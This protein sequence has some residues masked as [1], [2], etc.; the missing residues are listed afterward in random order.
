MSLKK[1]IL[2]NYT[3]Q[4]YATAV[5]IIMVPLYITYMGAEAYGLVGFFTMLQAWFNLLDM[6]FTP[7]MA[8][9]TAR[10]NG[11][12]LDILDYRRLARALEGV[13]L[14]TALLG[15]LLLFV[16]ADW[17]TQHWLNANKLPVTEITSALRLMAIIVAL[18]WMGGMYRGV[19]TGTER[20]VW[21]S[22]FNSIIA[23]LRFI[24]VLPVLM[25][26]SA[27]PSIFFQF[28]L[29]VAIFELIGLAWMAYRLLPDIPPGQHI[30]W[31]WAPL[32][33]VLKFS[34]SIAFTSSVGILITQTDKLILSKMLSL[35]DY[36]YFTVAV[37][38]ASGIIVM[39]GPIS[40]AL[41]PRLTKLNAL[42]DDNGLIK[43]YRNATQLVALIAI[44]ATLMLAF[45]PQQVL[46]VW[47][48]NIDISDKAAHTLMLY[49]LGN[50][51]FALAA[52]PYYLQF[53]K[54]DLKMHLISCVLFL[55]IFIPLLFWAV[56][57]Y[58]MAGAGYAWIA[59]NLLP[60]LWIPIIHKRF[61]PGLHTKWLLHDITPT[62]VL[63]T[64]AAFIL[65]LLISWPES[66]LAVSAWLL[67]ASVIL[68]A[69]AATSASWT[70][71]YALQKLNTWKK[72][73]CKKK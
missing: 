71:N 62:I 73:R 51:A 39:S 22:S 1:N 16:A 70:R 72:A 61:F 44:P 47:T 49:A 17:I 42:K 7:T 9:Q 13:F 63:S 40:A 32:K 4:L 52:F 55:L 53:A 36:G 58:G 59:S 11:G 18:R 31:E 35:T 41:I 29:G 34:L 15:G 10:F 21:L 5:G 37:L 46:W 38:A 20:L 19:I 43:L 27:T 33:P 26:I 25:F 30:H 68:C 12:A 64:I 50:G 14:S 54:G 45:F 24:F 23:T 48:G 2:A 6:G 57:N 28:Q 3:S 67:A 60:F 8:R 69:V 66:R 56:G 65:R